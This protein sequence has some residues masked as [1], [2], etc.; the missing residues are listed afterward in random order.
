MST[1]LH[2][3]TNSG[4]EGPDISGVVIDDGAPVENLYSEKLMRLL[5]EPLYASWV[6]PAGEDGAP[7]SFV[8]MADVGVFSTAADPPAVPDV[9]FALDVRVHPD[10]SHEKRHQTWFVWEFGKPPDVVIEIVSNR[11][12]GE[13]G[14]RRAAYE[15]MRVP[16]FVVWDPERLLRGPELQAFRLEGGQ[17][18][19][20]AAMVFPELGLSLAPWVGEYEGVAAR[21]LR[22]HADSRVVP[23][24]AEAANEARAQA[25]EALSTAEAERERADALAARLRELEARLAER[26]E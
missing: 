22:W 18:I 4:I 5:T 10:F 15:R 14:K 11:K 1:H 9:L 19:S 26:G 12:G 24:G 3:A 7:R 16:Y 2:S 13:L 21:W 25:R 17:Y 20:L 23:T 6:A 8:V